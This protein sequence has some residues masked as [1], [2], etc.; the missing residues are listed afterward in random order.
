MMDV[1]FVY[2]KNIFNF[3][4]AILLSVLKRHGLKACILFEEVEGEE[5]IARID[6]LNPTLVGFCTEIA[7]VLDLVEG[8]MRDNIE[9]LVLTKKSNAAIT[10]FVGGTHGT[11]LPELVNSEPAVDLLLYGD[12]ENSIVEVAKAL[13]AGHSIKGIPGVVFKDT[14]QVIDNNPPVPTDLSQLPFPDFQSFMDYPGSFRKGYRLPFARGCPNGCALCYNKNI[15]E[16]LH[17]EKKDL[18]RYYP[19]S[20]LIDAICYLKE[21]DPCFQTL[22]LVYGTFTSSK[23]FVKE[24]C[25]IYKDKVGIPYVIATRLDAIDDEISS[26]LKDSN[27]S[28][29][30]ISI[31]TANEQLRNEVLKKGLSNEDI[32]AGMISLK[33]YGLRV[34]CSVLFGFPDETLEDAFDTLDMSRKIKADFI[35]PS[36]FVPIPGLALTKYAIE[37]GHLPRNYNLSSFKKTI[38]GNREYRRLKNVLLLAPFYR[39]FPLRAFFKLLVSMPSNRFFHWIFHLPRMKA[40]MKY[41][42]GKASLVQKLHYLL[43]AHRAIF[44]ENRRPHL[45]LFQDRAEKERKVHRGSL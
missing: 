19:V 3:E 30:S 16:R 18:P 5:L 22:Y 15:A 7:Y 33:K 10:T 40:V 20:F 44:L 23:R 6:K 12:M 32:F 43:Q 4:V 2:K 27:C 34:G 36:I 8:E 28:K 1:I 29:V 24:F 42:L 38:L 25:T 17:L 35:G 11:I 41:D 14:G 45:I 31:E 13:G 39:I 21:H 37:K 9:L 26:L